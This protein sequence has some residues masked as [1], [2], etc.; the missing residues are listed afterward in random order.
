MDTDRTGEDHLQQQHAALADPHRYRAYQ[1]VVASAQPV[2]VAWLSSRIAIHHTALRRHLDKLVAAGLLS[3]QPAPA[4]GRGRPRRLYRAET[5]GPP[6]WA[7]PDPYRRLSSLLAEAVRTGRS[8]RETGHSIGTRLPNHN[9]DPVDAIAT[10]AMRLGFNPTVS[11]SGQDL[12]ITL[13]TCPFVDV[14][15]EDPATICQLHLGLAEGAAKA[16]GGLEVT[17]LEVRDPSVAGCVLRLRRTQDPP[18]AAT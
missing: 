12:R 10:E 18:A 2:D 3:T 15:A 16:L 5:I 7:L 6:A 1:L 17:G 8:A 9:G 14:A 13:E 11:G 4:G